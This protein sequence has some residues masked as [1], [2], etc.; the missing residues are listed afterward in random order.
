M[1]VEKRHALINIKAKYDQNVS[2]NWE[3]NMREKRTRGEYEENN[4]HFV[5]HSPN[6]G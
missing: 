3:E 6:K 4:T 1:S 5:H 2:F